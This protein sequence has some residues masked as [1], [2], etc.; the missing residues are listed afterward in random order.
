MQAFWFLW[1]TYRIMAQPLILPSEVFARTW[2]EGKKFLSTDLKEAM[3]FLGIALLSFALALISFYVPE[4][5]RLALRATDL[6]LLQIIGTSWVTLRLTTSVLAE[7]TGKK[8]KNPS[9]ALLGSFLLVS[10][11]NGLAVAGGA[12]FFVLP[13]IWLS[14]A[15]AFAVYALLDEG[16]SGRQALARSAELVKGRWWGTFFRLVLPVFVI[17][18]MS[19]M[20]S[21]FIEVLVG[22]IAGYRPSALISQVGFTNWTVLGAPATQ[23]A[24]GALQVI[25]AIPLVIAIP[26][27][28]H[29]MVTVYLELKR[30][31]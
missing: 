17:L 13:G 7:R 8:A 27:L 9:L 21:S 23:V 30:T 16:T 24:S 4:S 11:L 12:L 28:T 6:I 10:L 15:F 31:R 25:D 14:I 18:I 2:H 22:V 26:F 5:I 19:M 1:Y 29:L 3:G 20:A